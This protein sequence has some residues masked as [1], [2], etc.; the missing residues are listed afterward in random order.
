MIRQSDDA[1]AA[2]EDDCLRAVEN[3]CRAIEGYRVWRCRNVRSRISIRHSRAAECHWR[4]VRCNRNLPCECRRIVDWR[5]PR[6]ISSRVMHETSTRRPRSARG[7]TAC[8]SRSVAREQMRRGI[9]P[10]PLSGRRIRRSRG[11][12]HVKIGLESRRCENRRVC[13]YDARSVAGLCRRNW[14]LERGYA[15]RR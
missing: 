15:T 14:N 13:V 12:W 4:A 1:C 9:S 3:A 2:I 7:H 5:I 10:H 8:A 6:G 11:F